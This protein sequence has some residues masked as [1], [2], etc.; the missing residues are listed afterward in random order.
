MSRLRPS[1]V[2][3]LVVVLLAAALTAVTRWPPGP[4]TVQSAPDEATS[5]DS[6]RN[7]VRPVSSRTLVCP[8]G[9]ALL[10][11]GSTA[12]AGSTE[13][14]LVAPDLMAPAGSEATTPGVD[15]SRAVAQPLEPGATPL[16]LLTAQGPATT[17]EVTSADIGPVVVRTLGALAPGLT[18]SQ[19]STVGEG[20]A[21]GVAAAACEEPSAQAWFVGTGTELGHRPRLYLV[22]AEAAVAEVDVTLYGPDGPLDVSSLRGVAVAAGAVETVELD[23]VAPD[24]T[25]LA[26]EVQVGIGRVAAAVRDS[27]AEGLSSLG[28]EW[29]A[30]ASPPSTRVVI[31]GVSGSGGGERLLQLLAPGD[32]DARVQV[33]LWTRTGP[34]VPLGLEEVELTAGLVNSVDLAAALGAEVAAVELTADQ[35]I[36]A[37][38]R[39]VTS[40]TGAREMAYTA[41]SAPLAGPAVVA[42]VRAGAGWA[43]RL[44]LSADDGGPD[45]TALGTDDLPA[46]TTVLV[47]FVDATSGTV[48]GSQQPVIPIGSTVEVTLA[49]ADLPERFSVVV[50]PVF[51]VVYAALVLD[52]SGGPDAGITIL[53]LSSPQLFV[54]VPAV[55]H[56]PLTVL[57]FP[58]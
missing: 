20:D 34:I 15:A 44:L 55:R 51:G 4:I 6:A 39:A 33:R 8:D 45:G 28:V 35:P 40:G 49:G 29:L 52:R 16:A 11:A 24:L 48:V 47:R 53:P 42:A 9:S 31:P 5:T 41:G 36:V 25:R 46:E 56:D 21:T 50:T 10:A 57:R 32:L 2:L 22:N 23:A 19:L 13:V 54:E 7:G 3:G 58:G 14:T 26:V 37:G 30:H 17:A 1:L 27:R 43:G 12:S 38:L 18:A